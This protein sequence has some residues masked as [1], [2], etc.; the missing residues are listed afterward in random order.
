MGRPR[1]VS[2]VDPLQFTEH[3]RHGPGPHW[4]DRLTR[5]WMHAGEQHDELLASDTITQPELVAEPAIR[6]AH[7]RCALLRKIPNKLFWRAGWRCAFDIGAYTA[8]GHPNELRLPT[9]NT[10]RFYTSDH[11]KYVPLATRECV[12]EQDK[13]TKKTSKNPK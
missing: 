11:T 2:E 4:D 3:S 5:Y 6:P 1:R 9:R 13:H 12:S 7:D 8:R 10:K